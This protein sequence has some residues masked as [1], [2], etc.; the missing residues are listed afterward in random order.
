MPDLFESVARQLVLE[1]ILS[2]REKARK[3][4]IELRDKMLDFYQD[5]QQSKASYFAQY[6]F[7][8]KRM[9]PFMSSRLTKRVIDKR[10]LVYKKQPTRVLLDQSGNPIKDDGFNAFT[11]DN[12]AFQVMLKQAERHKNLLNNLLFRW[13]WN[14]ERGFLWYIEDKYEP[15][16]SAD[17]EIYP[18]GY[19]IPM[20]PQANGKKVSD[21]IF[22]CISDDEYFFI[23]KA[24][25]VSY[26]P[27]FPDGINPYGRMPIVDYSTPD[28]DFYWTTGAKSLVEVNQNLILAI[29]AALHGIR[30][31][32]FSQLWSKIRNTEKLPKNDKGQPQLKVGHTEV[33]QLE[34]DDEIGAINFSPSLVET[35][36][37]I[38]RW[39][40]IELANWGMKANFRESGNPMSGFALVV[41]NLDLLEAREDDLDHYR[42]LEQDHLAILREMS[43][44]HGLS[45]YEIPEGASLETEFVKPEFP[46][47]IDEV[48]REREEDLKYNLSTPID[49]LMQRFPG[50]TRAEAEKKI[51]E[52]RDVNRRLTARTTGIFNAIGQAATATPPSPA[53]PQE[54]NEDN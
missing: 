7:A 42:P 30:F 54:G 53:E 48:S 4:R 22:L 32:S 21:P 45:E 43:R 8:E 25:V 12:P 52:N 33:I 13:T 46:K 41:S 31:Q 9:L 18:I 27:A 11:S 34:K 20:P 51:E 6:G 23:N 14:E 38:E 5:N 10:S 3:E 36:E 47:S 39:L 29:Y 40:N 50:M 26:D 17:N 28:I 2:A 49:W 37:F 1:S 35:M 15:I 44:V 19:K 24:G 16:F